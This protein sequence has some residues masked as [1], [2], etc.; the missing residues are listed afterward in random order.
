MN[1]FFCASFLT[2]LATITQKLKIEKSEILFFFRFSRFQIFHVNLNTFEK[3]NLIKN[4]ITLLLFLLVYYGRGKYT[5]FTYN[6]FISILL[7]FSYFYLLF[8]ILIFLF[9]RHLHFF[10]LVFCG[11]GC[12]CQF[13]C[14][15]F[16]DADTNIRYITNP[17]FNGVK[18]C[19]I[20]L[21][22][23]QWIV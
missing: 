13:V 21:L 12:C 18:K 11:C 10:S 14:G 3:K 17:W 22:G 23:L 16:V 7:T 4:N 15:C 9:Y 1:N 20:N 19:D 5:I 6:L 2:S 8:L